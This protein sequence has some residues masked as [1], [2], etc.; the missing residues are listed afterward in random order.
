MGIFVLGGLLMARKG[1][2]E[3]DL[4]ILYFENIDV[5]TGSPTTAEDDE[6][7]PIPVNKD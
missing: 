2:E 4:E 7:P 1:Y 6:L 3:L 5:I